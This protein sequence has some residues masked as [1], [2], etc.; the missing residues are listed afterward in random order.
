MYSHPNLMKL[1]ADVSR[2]SPAV[3][4]TGIYL[5]LSTIWIFWS[6][7]LVEKLA[8]NNSTLL[9]NLQNQKGIAFV[10]LSSILL[11]VISHSL[12]NRLRNSN[13]SKTTL[14][15]K[16]EA[17]N[18]AAR[19]GMIDYDTETKT[20]TINE[21]MSFFMPS[22]T[23]KIENFFQTFMERIHIADHARVRSEY[24]MA[25]ETGQNVWTTEYRLL[26]TDGIYYSV[27]SSLFLIRDPETNKTHRL[28]GEIQDITQLRN[29]QAEYYNQ[30]LKHKQ[31]LAST[32]IKA[33]ENERNRWAQE[34]H[35][36]ISQILTVIN[37]YLGNT[38]VKI[39]RNITMIN[40]AKKMVNEVQQEIRF[41]SAAMKPPVFSLMTLEQSL[42]K[43][44]ADITRVKKIGFSL[45]A[46]ELDETKLNDE[47][48]LMIY[49]VVQEQLN[50]ILKYAEANHI[51]ISLHSENELVHIQLTD[52]GKGFDSI[53]IKTGLGFRNIQ[54]RLLVYNGDMK[55]ESSP[56]KG[57][58]LSVTFHI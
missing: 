39:D 30:Q 26:G 41:L 15:Q 53:K 27:L 25:N 8:H 37:L 1:Q 50:N 7:A 43:L 44:I 51:D 49:R 13:K 3:F 35:D 57:C 11:F 9:V 48:K 22:G 6:D 40:E 12:Y 58:R 45:T 16:F 42:D 19:G 55:L 56:G 17:L 2:C 54:S 52:D 5:T 18:V 29:L 34:L 33:Q 32:I 38:N 36:N 23:H 14:E 4:I 10:L 31:R 21:K 20:A 24:E 28:I 47:Q 46:S